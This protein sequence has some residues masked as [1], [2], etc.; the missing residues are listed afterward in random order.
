MD[1]LDVRQK[2]KKGEIIRK[3]LDD[4]EARDVKTLKEK[5]LLVLA[6]AYGECKEEFSRLDGLTWP[7]G[8]NCARERGRAFHIDIFV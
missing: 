4:P 6:L 1:E 3:I 8:M 2:M 5:F 7:N